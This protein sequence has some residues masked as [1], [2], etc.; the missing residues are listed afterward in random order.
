MPKK[1]RAGGGTPAGKRESRS[2]RSSPNSAHPAVQED[3]EILEEDL[4]AG[5][6]AIQAIQSSN[7]STQVKER[8]TAL[9]SKFLA[10]RDQ[11][12][13]LQAAEAELLKLNLNLVP[14]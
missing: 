12:E 9:G 3:Y 13:A 5:S 11:I 1:S 7:A 10:Q 6:E 14:S 8:V 2:G 4:E